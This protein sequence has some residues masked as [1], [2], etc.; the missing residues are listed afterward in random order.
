M[1]PTWL[2]RGVQ[3][4]SVFGLG[5]GVR[6]SCGKSASQDNLILGKNLQYQQA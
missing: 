2:L 5:F 3:Q 1:L 4:I 6:V